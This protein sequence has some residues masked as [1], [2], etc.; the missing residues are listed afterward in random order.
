MYVLLFSHLD[1][2]DEI[3][4]E[5]PQERFLDVNHEGNSSAESVPLRSSPDD[6]GVNGQSDVVEIND[7]RSIEETEVV[8]QPS[9]VNEDH[10]RNP[11]VIRMHLLQ[12]ES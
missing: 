3:T 8:L 7:Q 2:N 11:Y 10:D 4:S 1:T 6:A 9:H 12:R 5:E